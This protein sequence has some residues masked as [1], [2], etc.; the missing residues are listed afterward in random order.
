MIQE[1]TSISLEEMI[2][3]KHS[4]RME[5]ADRILDDLIPAARSLGGDQAGRA[6]DVLEAWDRCADADSR[7]AVLFEAFCRELFRRF[8][9]RDDAF[10][11]GWSEEHPMTTP[12]GLSDPAA[13]VRALEA[14]ARAIEREHGS[15]DIAWGDLHRL[16]GE[17]LDLPANGGPQWLG[18]FREIRFSRDGD[19]LYSPRSGD[20]YICAVEFSDPVRGMALLAYGNAS[21]PGSMHRTDQL[22]L[23]A[24]KELRPVWFSRG[25]IEAHLELHERF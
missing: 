16:R 17:G 8:P 7:G 14:A 22:P 1:D 3:Y 2:A 6:A 23:L 9:R 12:D 18:I 15:L 24:R 11:T 21:Q 13:A 5:L 4:T 20:S 19:G 10:A 25:E